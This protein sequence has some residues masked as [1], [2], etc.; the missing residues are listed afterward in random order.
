MRSTQPS[1]DACRRTERPLVA[2]ERENAVHNAGM[3]GFRQSRKANGRQFGGPV[4]ATPRPGAGRPAARVSPRACSYSAG[5]GR[6]T[7]SRVGSDQ[8][9]LPQSGQLPSNVCAPCLTGGGMDGRSRSRSPGT[10]ASHAADADRRAERGYDRAFLHMLVAI[11]GAFKSLPRAL[12]IRVERW[13][14]KLSEPCTSNSFRRNRNL[15]AALLAAMVRTGEFSEPF[16]GM[17]P[18][19]RL[20]RLPTHL[21]SDWSMQCPVRMPRLASPLAS[22]L[23][24]LRPPLRRPRLEIPLPCAD[25][26]RERRGETPASLVQQGCRS[27]APHTHCRR[28]AVPAIPATAVTTTTPAAAP[29][30]A[31]AAR[32][33]ST[34]LLLRVQPRSPSLGVGRSGL[35]HLRSSWERRQNPA[36][37]LGGSNRPRWLE[38]SPS[39]ED[40]RRAAARINARAKRPGSR[41]PAKISASVSADPT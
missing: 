7:A 13:V 1:R 24:S 32:Q 11:D 37:C 15:H 23:V 19:G 6:P 5:S 41:Y 8:A 40:C 25:A 26:E 16:T 17:P 3:T 21:V 39:Q 31:P 29:A 33:A 27:R 14:L 18:D 22:V 9:H 35:R 4:I 28:S 12:Q 34:G 38:P 30:P 2:M 36:G 10:D 20:P